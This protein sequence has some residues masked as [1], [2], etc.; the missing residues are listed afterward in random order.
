MPR[1]VLGHLSRRRSRSIGLALALAVAAAASTLLLAETKTSAA[2]V[3]GVV[4]GNWRSAYDVVVRPRSS[5]TPLERRDGLVRP[6]YLSGIYGGIS[7]A[8]WRR[9]ERISGVEV[10]A[11]VANVGYFFI[12]TTTRVDLKRRLTSRRRQLF[13]ISFGDTADNGLSRFPWYRGY[14]YVYYTHNP[15]MAGQEGGEILPHHPGFVS[16]CCGLGAPPAS[17][18]PFPKHPGSGM[19]TFS[20][21]SPG[22]GADHP[23]WGLFRPP[24]SVGAPVLSALPVLLA[25]IDPTEEAKLLHLDRAVVDGRYL[26]PDEGLT[27][28]PMPGMAYRQHVVPVLASTR[29]YIGN[30]RTIRVERLRVPEGPQLPEKLASHR[31]YRY[32]SSRRGPTI[33]RLRLPY[34]ELWAR[35]VRVGSDL[36]VGDYWWPS[37][38][39]YA[40]L[41]R[42]HLG[43]VPVRNPISIWRSRSI[44]GGYEAPPLGNNDT[45]FR[46][47]RARKGNNVFQSDGYSPTPV[48]RVVGRYDPVSLPRFSPLSRVPLETY[49]PPTLTGADARSRALLEGRPLGPSLNL[50]DYVSQ[51]PLLLTTMQGL[52]TMVNPT[53]FTPIDPDT[54]GYTDA[55]FSGERPAP[56]W[57]RDLAPISVIRVRVARVRGPDATSRARIAQV[58]AEIR[59]KTGLAVD[60]T[61]GSSP[62]P[63]TVELPAGRFGRPRLSLTEGW[64]QKGAAVEFLRAT[65]RKSLALLLLIP[66][67]C[68]LFVANGVLANVRA[69]RSEIGTLLCLGWPRPQIFKA[70]L[71]EVVVVAV[72][73]GLAAVPF[74]AA[75]AAALSLD[76]RAAW[77][78]LPLPLALLVAVAAALAPAAH[79]ASLE[80][81]AA[82]RPPVTAPVRSERPIRRLASLALANVR[83]L[84][85][86]TLLATVGLAVGVAAFTILLAVERA[87]HG[88]VVGTLLGNAVSLAVR[89]GDFAA[90][91]FVLGLSGL[92]L[93]DAWA[94][95]IRDR[96]PELATLRSVGWSGRHIAIVV[97][98]EGVWVGAAGGLIG[99]LAGVVVAT[100]VL[101]VSAGPTVLAGAF[102]IVGAVALVTIA[103]LLPAAVLQRA[104]AVA[105]LAAE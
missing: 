63:L 77:L 97:A 42:D 37:P 40:I 89:P 92:V 80:P 25:A 22:G 48:L 21:A 38:S 10:A 31:S 2:R 85:V 45:Q 53:Y 87:F 41:G 74:A 91:G 76:V 34:A 24:G 23:D 68:G 30:V 20:R 54:H 61:A 3:H 101:G 86:A 65:D 43:V 79:A 84:P 100:A 60:V 15:F 18:G 28:K 4:R 13:R 44:S 12:W 9:I 102:G 36:P 70:V 5:Y 95:S 47:L 104:P 88:A 8:E 6:N 49:Y 105:S 98:L 57:G 81:I 69:R 78:L 59:R 16:T 33:E 64:S 73:A 93:C 56:H 62:H 46:R 1:F 67:V 39:R 27:S 52:R 58:A 35:H 66:I 82:V 29:S 83:R 75:V 103:A 55:I 51:P 71:G 90:V 14:Y 50:G 99:S 32:V 72:V 17:S 11:P 26:R 7:F 96:A 94:I 19:L